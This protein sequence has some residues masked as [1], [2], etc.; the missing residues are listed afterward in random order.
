MIDL[1]H[2]RAA[3]AIERADELEREIQRA[4]F[5]LAAG[6]DETLVQAAAR[7]M[8]EVDDA[9]AGARKERRR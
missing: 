2:E 8:R 5:I 7:V 1:A 3:E 6:R 9:R 4:R